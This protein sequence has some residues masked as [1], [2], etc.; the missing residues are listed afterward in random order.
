MPQK[1]TYEIRRPV[2]NPNWVKGGRSPNPR[3]ISPTRTTLREVL[4]EV[5]PRELRDIMLEIA[6]GEPVIHYTDPVT[7]KPKRC[8][9]ELPDG[10][11]AG[12]VTRVEH[13][14]HADRQRAVEWLANR[15]DPQSKDV[16]VEVS[17]GPDALASGPD[18]ARLTPEQLDQYIALTAIASGPAPMLTEGEEQEGGGER[19]GGDGEP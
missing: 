6:R 3:G 14:T 1:G 12:N 10:V 17:R 11:P 2:G 4:Q 5:D 8:T 19:S 18:L 9:G 7:A 16:K 15:R 13:P